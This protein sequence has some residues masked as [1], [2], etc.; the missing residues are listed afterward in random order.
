MYSREGH[1]NL[2]HGL[3]CLV[4][5]LA[6]QKLYQ[7]RGFTRTRTEGPESVSSK[8]LSYSFLNA[9]LSWSRVFHS[10]CCETYA[11][12]YVGGWIAAADEGPLDSKESAQPQSG[13]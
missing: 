9:C 12:N 4:W 11:V 3:Q 13:V 7:E 6:Q 8:L 10:G 1:M 2:S 5:Y